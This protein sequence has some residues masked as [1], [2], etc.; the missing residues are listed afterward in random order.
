MSK[1]LYDR[2]RIF[3]R[4]LRFLTVKSCCS[5]SLVET[6]FHSS[7]IIWVQPI[8]EL[9]REMK[10]SWFY[11]TKLT[12]LLHWF[13]LCCHRYLHSSQFNCSNSYFGTRFA[14]R[15]KL[16]SFFFSPT[17]ELLDLNHFWQG[18]I[19]ENT[20]PMINCLLESSSVHCLDEVYE[21]ATVIVLCSDNLFIYVHLY[22]KYRGGLHSFSS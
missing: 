8:L 1:V 4:D 2:I 10:C 12:V 5:R 20:F 21:H 13:R 15:K 22:E 18:T 14:F 11:V 6:P 16:L 9:W 17:T 7:A 3:K 19:T